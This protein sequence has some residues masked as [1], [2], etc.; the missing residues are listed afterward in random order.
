VRPVYNKPFSSRK[1]KNSYADSETPLPTTKEKGAT[2][3]LSAVKRLQKKEQASMG[4]RRVA[5]KY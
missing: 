3:V 4:I 2:V 1:W 5:G